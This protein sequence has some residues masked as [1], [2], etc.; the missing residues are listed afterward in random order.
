VP[1]VFIASAFISIR[2]LPLASMA[3]M[4]FL[5]KNLGHVSLNFHA[6]GHVPEVQAG[7]LET[8]IGSISHK[9]LTETQ[10]NI[11]N[12]LLLIVVGVVL[13]FSYSEIRKRQEADVAA[14]LPV[15]ATDFLVANHIRGRMFNSYRYG[16]YLIFR[17]YPAQKVFIYGWVEIYQDD[18]VKKLDDILQGRPNWKTLFDSYNIDYVICDSEVALRQLLLQEGDFRLVYDDGRSSVL[19]RKIERFNDI[20]ANLVQHSTL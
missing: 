20:K 15:G 11:I 12:W 10:V 9:A 19:L 17:L 2:N 13:I 3:L 14:Y 8:L 18:F 6:K 4:P 1:L 7:T 5:A 16:G